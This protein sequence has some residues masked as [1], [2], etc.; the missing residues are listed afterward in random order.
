MPCLLGA[1]PLMD[2]VDIVG[3]SGV[4]LL[5]GDDCGGAVRGVQHSFRT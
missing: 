1:W 2:S 4:S 5:L 3:E